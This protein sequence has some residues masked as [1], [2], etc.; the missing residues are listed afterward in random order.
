MMIDLVQLR[1][2]VAVAEEEHLTRAAERL[3]ISQSAASGHVRAVEDALDT[4]LFVRTSR[5]LQLT[6]AGKRLMQ[7][8]KTVLHEASQLTAFAREIRG[9]IEGT[10]V[11]GAG[12]DPS[13]NRIG[14]VVSAL[15]AQHELISVDLHVRNSASTRQA[16]KTGE[17]DVGMLLGSAMDVGLTCYHLANLQFRIAGPAAWRDQIEA[18]DWEQ[19]AGL[20][21]IT[22]ADD[23]LAYSAMLNQL[24]G[25]RGLTLN[26][27][28]RCDSTALG[29]SLLED[30]VGMMLMRDHQALQGERE[31]YLALAPHARA[32]FGAYIAHV[33]TRGNDPLIQAFVDAVKVAWPEM[34]LAAPHSP[35]N[36]P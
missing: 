12:S 34:K 23:R 26:T 36:L 18:A 11:I 16:L 6:V 2:F 14:K 29:R 13:L 15:R 32:E 19:L 35:H 8:A 31:G 33:S 24:F 9:K 22:P 7:Q 25:Q 3:H 27:V 21:W 20:P 10:I 1:T 4:R 28:V 5:S 17:V 30:G